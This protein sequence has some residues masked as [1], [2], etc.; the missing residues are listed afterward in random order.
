MIGAAMISG[1]MIGGEG[2][3]PSPAAPGLGYTGLIVCPPPLPTVLLQE[4]DSYF[5]V[6]PCTYRTV[7]SCAIWQVGSVL[8]WRWPWDG[9]G[10]GGWRVVWRCA[11]AA[12]QSALVHHRLGHA[13]PLAPAPP[14]PAIPHCTTTHLPRPIPPLRCPVQIEWKDLKML[15]AFRPRLQEQMAVHVHKALEE[16]ITAY[17]HLWAHSLQVWGAAQ[18][19]SGMVWVGR[20]E[21]GSWIGSGC[22]CG[23]GGA[24]CLEASGAR[25]CCSASAHSLFGTGTASSEQESGPLT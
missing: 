23:G 1:A 6:Y 2:F 10:W 24:S 15:L 13:R 9:R 5:S 12:P 16:R 14:G 3:W 18:L 19:P 21:A 22:V 11:G 17:P 25:A 4:L 7:T 20:L 8:V